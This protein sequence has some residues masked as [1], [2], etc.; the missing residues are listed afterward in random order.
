MESRTRVLGRTLAA[1][2]RS[3]HRKARL[4]LP[5]A[6]TKWP[7]RL[8]WSAPRTAF[9]K[10]KVLVCMGAP[11]LWGFGGHKTTR[12][13]YYQAGSC[14]FKTGSPL[15]QMSHQPRRW[16]TPCF[17]RTGSALTCSNKVIVTYAIR[18]TAA[19]AARI[20]ISSDPCRTGFLL[21]QFLA[22]V[23]SKRGI[24]LFGLLFIKRLNIFF[25]MLH[26]ICIRIC[27]FSVRCLLSVFFLFPLK[28]S[29]WGT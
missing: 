22:H 21:S 9:R 7:E 19:H 27:Y 12:S 29:S 1:G 5:R 11:V 10:A 6:P 18:Q 8:I 25:H 3:G 28:N 26:K 20:P 2:V 14:I 15:P 16:Q 4:E 17:F 24:Y 13:S 23:R